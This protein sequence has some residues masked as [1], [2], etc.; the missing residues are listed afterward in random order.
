VRHRGGRIDTDELLAL[1]VEPAVHV[2]L[3]KP[4]RGTSF[5]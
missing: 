3:T 4:A 5:A 1:A 2:C